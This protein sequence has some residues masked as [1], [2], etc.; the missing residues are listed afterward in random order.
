VTR[1]GPA[2]AAVSGPGDTAVGGGGGVGGAA[3]AGQSLADDVLHGG[4]IVIVSLRPHIGAVVLRSFPFV[5]PMAFAAF[6]GIFWIGLPRNQVAGSL[7]LLIALVFAWQAVDWSLTRYVLTDRRVMVVRGGS[8]FAGRVVRES[9]LPTVHRISL[10]HSVRE[11]LI[12]LGT[13]VFVPDHGGRVVWEML[14]RAEDVY[15]I[16]HEAIERYGRGRLS[17]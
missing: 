16:A 14:G 7:G 11:S 1:T 6:A 10:E 3:L 4:E 12:G 8:G 13:L 17:E 15:S 2:N 5:I 9:L